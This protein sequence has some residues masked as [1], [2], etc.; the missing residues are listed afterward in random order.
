MIGD[1]EIEFSFE[2][3]FEVD[4]HDSEQHRALAAL[5]DTTVWSDGESVWF[6]PDVDFELPPEAEAW[7]AY[8]REKD[9]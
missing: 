1:K 9:D 5:F 2:V 4:P 8:H 7:L 6:G 3:E